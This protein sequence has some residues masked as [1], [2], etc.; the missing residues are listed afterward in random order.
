MTRMK[1]FL[2]SCCFR[3]VCFLCFLICLVPRVEAAFH[4]LRLPPDSC[5]SSSAVDTLR[6]RGILQVMVFHGGESSLVFHVFASAR[7][8]FGKSP[9]VYRLAWAQAPF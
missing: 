4:I 7:V 9:D 8:D 6:S 1:V 3:H 5:S 2:N